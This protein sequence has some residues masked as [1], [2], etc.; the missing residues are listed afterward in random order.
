M[1]IYRHSFAGGDPGGLAGLAQQC[2]GC[3]APPVRGRRGHLLQ[4]LV[5]G[6]QPRASGWRLPA[7]AVRAAHVPSAGF[8]GAVPGTGR[9]ETAS[10]PKAFPRD[11]RN[12]VLRFTLKG[13]LELRG[14]QLL[15]LV[16]SKTGGKYVNYVLTGQPMEV[17]PE[18][19]CRT[20]HLTLRSGPVDVHRFAA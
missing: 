16:Q 3:R 19:N 6:L 17:M 8:S 14:A 5:G 12:A 11:F 20:L 7:P 10:W 13:E 18:W 4:S 9:R 2:R 15:L 1:R